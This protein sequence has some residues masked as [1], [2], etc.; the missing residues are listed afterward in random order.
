MDCVV[1]S[2]PVG[3]AC[4]AALLKR[5]RPVL[6]L[7]AGLR[8]EP[9]R[10]KVVQQMATQTPAEW[11]SEN[12]ARIKEGM[13]P[14]AKGIPQKLLFG[15]DFPYRDT[16]RELGLYS[17]GVGLQASLAMGGLSTVWGSAMMGYHDR[18]LA[19]WPIRKPVIWPRTIAPCWSR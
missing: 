1:G 5:G 8:L 2:G 9:D 14:G 13:N 12:I 4:A 19:D 7:D 11:S 16:E 18:D 17:S 3:V 15:S 10:A 6:M